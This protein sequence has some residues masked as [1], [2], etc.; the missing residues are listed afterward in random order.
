MLLM[1]IKQDNKNLEG[2]WDIYCKI[3]S[4]RSTNRPFKLI[5]MENG[6]IVSFITIFHVMFDDPHKIYRLPG[7]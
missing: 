4:Y 5:A 1:S 7:K 3:L 6:Y 2:K